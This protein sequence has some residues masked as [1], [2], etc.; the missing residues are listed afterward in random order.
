V[1][2]PVCSHPTSRVLRTDAYDEEIKRRRECEQCRHR[3]TSVE[4]PEEQ[5][6][7]L[8][9]LLERLKPVKELMP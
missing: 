8:D 4:V 5:I 1:I 2:C 9:K 7:L 6:R 3:W